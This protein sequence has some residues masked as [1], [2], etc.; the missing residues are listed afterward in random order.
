MRAF[1]I[2]LGGVVAAGTTA[3]ALADRP[4][5]PARAS[6][7]PPVSASFADSGTAS[8]SQADPRDDR[9]EGLPPQRVPSP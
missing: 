7:H 1:L 6:G 9:D 5:P 4:A 3:L 8:L 2:T